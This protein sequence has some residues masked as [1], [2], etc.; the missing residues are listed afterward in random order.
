MCNSSRTTRLDH[1]QTR[2]TKPKHHILPKWAWRIGK[3]RSQV[4][5]TTKLGALRRVSSQRLLW[6][7]KVCL[8]RQHT[9]Q[10][11]HGSLKIIS[12]SKPRRQKWQWLQT[13]LRRKSRSDQ[14]ATAWRWGRDTMAGKPQC[15]LLA[16]NRSFFS[17]STWE[18]SPETLQDPVHTKKIT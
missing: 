6:R 10:S 13:F 11:L 9:S 8:L 4:K 18:S 5:L 12:R 17:L 16:L 7:G 2:N 15:H 3:Q 1:G 14:V